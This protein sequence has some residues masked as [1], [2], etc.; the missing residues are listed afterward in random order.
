MRRFTTNKNYKD[1]YLKK[2][3]ITSLNLRFLI[4]LVVNEKD[5]FTEEDAIIKILM[6]RFLNVL[7]L[8]C[9]KLAQDFVKIQPI[10]TTEV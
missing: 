9:W 3:W 10:Q 2:Y 6:K 1:I 7:F 5:D 8:V 4:I